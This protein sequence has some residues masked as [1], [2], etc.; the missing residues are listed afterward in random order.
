MNTSRLC[1]LHGR[2]ER[3]CALLLPFLLLAIRF[4]VANVFFKSGL[5]KIADWDTTLFLFQEEY[6]VPFLPPALAAVMGTAGELGL[7]VL[8]V[9]GLFGR[10]AGAGLFILN[11]TAVVSYPT[12]R[13]DPA[14]LAMHIHW[15]IMIAV[16]TL[17]GP[18]MIALDT[19]VKKWFCR[20]QAL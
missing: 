12:V 20:K 10:F 9:L 13:D 11:I 4:Y 19:L 3:L 8:L 1:Y 18:G 14:L 2:V 16:L 7:S 17:T 5:T 6:H 15:G